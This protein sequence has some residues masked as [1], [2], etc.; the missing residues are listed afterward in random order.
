MGSAGQMAFKE[1]CPAHWLPGSD[2]SHLKCPFHAGGSKVLYRKVH[3]KISHPVLKFSR[4]WG[5]NMITILWISAVGF[6]HLNS[7]WNFTDS[8]AQR[9]CLPHLREGCFGRGNWSSCKWDVLFGTDIT[10]SRSCSY[11]TAVINMCR[12][13]EQLTCYECQLTGQEIFVQGGINHRQWGKAADVFIHMELEINIFLSDTGVNAFV[14]IMYKS[15]QGSEEIFRLHSLGKGLSLCICTTPLSL[16]PL[17]ISV[18]NI[19]WQE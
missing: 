11:N 4:F 12:F 19:T 3:K 15:L 7:Y 16:D 14:D 13:I 17:D 18:T 6:L 5:R 9:I 10:S 1:T 2:D 8:I